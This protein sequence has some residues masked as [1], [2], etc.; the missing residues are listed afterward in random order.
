MIFVAVGTQKF[1]FNRLLSQLDILIETG[2][3]QE[4]VFA[5][6]GHSGY[7]PKHYEAVPF[8]DKD[9]FD[10]QIAACDLLVTHSGVG[11]IMA[12]MKCKKPVVVV[13]RL[14]EYGEHVDD[15]Q[16]E[17]AL[18]FQQK[19]FVAVC[20]QINSLSDVILQ[21]KETAFQ[22]YHSQRDAVLDTIRSYLDTL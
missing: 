21:A 18:A 20:T 17:I 6:I 15:H 12:A 3:L 8:L 14:A 7:T 11:S 13:P 19:N 4:P 1:P 10:E 16:L 5:Q 9:A 22:T 2:K